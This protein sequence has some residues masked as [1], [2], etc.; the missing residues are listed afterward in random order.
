VYKTHAYG[1]EGRESCANT[2][3]TSAGLCDSSVDPSKHQTCNND[4]YFFVVMIA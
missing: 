4:D 2:S 1:E 3:F